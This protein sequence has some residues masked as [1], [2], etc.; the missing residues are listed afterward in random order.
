MKIANEIITQRHY[1]HKIQDMGEI[2]G[3]KN[4]QENFFISVHRA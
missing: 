3:S 4:E 2:Y 1:D